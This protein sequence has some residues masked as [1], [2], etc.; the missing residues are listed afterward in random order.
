MKLYNLVSGL[1]RIEREKEE[2]GESVYVR[3]CEWERVWEHVDE[4]SCGRDNVREYDSHTLLSLTLYH[5][6]S[7][8][9]SHIL[10]LI[11]SHS[12]LLLI[13]SQNLSQTLSDSLT[14]SHS[15]THPY[16]PSHFLTCSLTYPPTHILSHSIT[17]IVRGSH[18][19][20]FSYILS[21]IFTL[22][23]NLSQFLAQTLWH[24][25]T[26]SHIHVL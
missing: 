1:Y 23:H 26:F 16:T 5:T 17:H 8:T 2:E 14:Y 25:L 13:F 19:L 11:P 4:R 21:L 22:S 15:Y 12:H 10:S 9:I 24:S 20:R 18:F 3:E 6:L 7:F